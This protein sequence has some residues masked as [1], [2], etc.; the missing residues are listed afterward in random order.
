MFSNVRKLLRDRSPN[1]LNTEVNQNL[2]QNL[3]APLAKG[4]WGDLDR[5]PEQVKP[6]LNKS[7]PGEVKRSQKKSDTVTNSPLLTANCSLPT[8]KGTPH[9]RRIT[10]VFQALDNA[11]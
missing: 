2:L 5:S 1:W 11:P 3:S 9:W 4:G 6:S 7:L 8:V 10:Q